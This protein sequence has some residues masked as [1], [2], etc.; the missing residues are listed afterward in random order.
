MR[1][2]GFSPDGTT[3]YAVH[4]GTVLHSWSMADG[5]ELGTI[6]LQ[7]QNPRETPFATIFTPGGRYVLGGLWVQANPPFGIRLWDRET[8]KPV[9]SFAGHTNLAQ[10]VAMSPDGTHVASSADDFSVRVWETESGRQVACLDNLD[11]NVSSV[12]FSPDGKNIV[13]GG[14][15]SAVRVF[16]IAMQKERAHFSGHTGKVDCV[17]YSPDGR[18]VASGGNDKTIRPWQLP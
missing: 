11:S 14:A 1:A 7:Q 18:L 4:S 17:G 5:T 15:D 10:S 6:E 13:T 8:G 2:V 16:N 3:L 9:R 12:A